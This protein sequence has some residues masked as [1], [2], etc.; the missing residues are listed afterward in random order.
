MH[1]G[2]ALHKAASDGDILTAK[3]LLMYGACLER[4]DEWGRTPL[5]VAVWSGQQGMTRLLVDAGADLEAEAQGGYTPYLLAKK[6]G[7]QSLA[8]FLARRG[9]NVGAQ[10][11]DDD[12]D[13]SYDDEEKWHGPVIGGRT[14]G[15]MWGEHEIETGAEW[16]GESE[17]E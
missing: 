7:E 2:E 8:D 3:I 15:A 10:A 5:H 16:N 4:T 6:E 14:D 17:N 13:F 1:G 11:E 9:A 12:S